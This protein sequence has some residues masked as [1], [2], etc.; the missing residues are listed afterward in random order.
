MYLSIGNVCRAL[1]DAH[2]IQ[3]CLD[4]CLMSESE[5]WLKVIEVRNCAWPGSGYSL[6]SPTFPPFIRRY[7]IVTVTDKDICRVSFYNCC[8]QKKRLRNLR[9]RGHMSSSWKVTN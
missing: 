9:R 4:T 7:V 1:F 8:Y 5:T 3:R 6:S 2:K